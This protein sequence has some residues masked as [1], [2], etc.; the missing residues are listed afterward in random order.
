MTVRTRTVS[1]YSFEHHCRLPNH[2]RTWACPV[3]ERV[4]TH[5]KSGSWSSSND[6]VGVIQSVTMA[7]A[8]GK[9]ETFASRLAA[10]NTW[11]LYVL[12]AWLIFLV[13]VAVGR[14]T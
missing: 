6:G 12:V 5:E 4:W 10:D 7:Y 9:T 11:V 1:P 14:V 13:G 3:C 8:S 2:G